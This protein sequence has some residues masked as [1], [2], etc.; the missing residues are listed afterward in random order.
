MNWNAIPMLSICLFAV[1]FPDRSARLLERFAKFA[2]LGFHLRL[3]RLQ[4]IE[5]D[6]RKLERLYTVRKTY[7]QIFA[8]LFGGLQLYP[9]FY[10]VFH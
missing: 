6:V 7:I 4:G 1:I 10:P 8:A 5:P 2:Y 9:L 3:L